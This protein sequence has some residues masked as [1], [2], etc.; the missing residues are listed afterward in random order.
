[1]AVDHYENFPVASLLIP[2]RLRRAVV[3]IYRFARSADDIADEGEATP[4]MRLASLEAYRA[5]LDLV[6]GTQTTALEAELNTLDPALPAV[7]IP[8]QESMVRHQLPLQPFYDLL[9]AF[10]QDVTTTRYA[11]DAALFDYCRRSANPVG[12][13]MLHLYGA[14]TPRNLEDADAIC[15]GLQLTNF[16]QD[17]AIDWAKDRVYIPQ[18]RLDQFRV[19]E[20]H[21]A[22]QDIDDRWKAL[23]QHQVEQARKLLRQGYNLPSRLPLRLGLE[24]RM[25]IQGGLRILERLDE[26]NYDM[27]NHRPTL[28]Y[29][30]WIVVL[31]RSLMRNAAPQPD[32]NA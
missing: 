5:A 18:A 26:L 2:R 19:S 11:D 10:S 20:Q 31:G 28:K 8:L 1:M 12:H 15:T 29:R 17:V 7:F 4:E 23:M 6:A 14:A 32:N 24:L 13:L 9:S 25:V 22:R 21:I 30:D 27:F 16:W 3:D